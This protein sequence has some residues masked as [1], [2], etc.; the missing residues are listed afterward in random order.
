MMAIF[1]FEATDGCGVSS[2]ALAQE[3]EVAGSGWTRDLRSHCDRHKN[4][5]VRVV[6]RRVNGVG[7]GGGQAVFIQI[8]TRIRLK[9]GE[10][11]VKIRLK[12]GRNPLKSCVLAG[13]GR[14]LAGSKR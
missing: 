6:R 3:E 12:S 1:S 7:R 13:T 8:F 11:P 2:D 4:P 14:T 9:S 10:S 5:V